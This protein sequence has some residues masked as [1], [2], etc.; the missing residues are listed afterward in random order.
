M[1]GIPFG[2]RS[3]GN[4]YFPPKSVRWEYLRAGNG[5]HTCTWKGEARYYD[6]V[7]NDKV[8]RNAGWSYP[9]PKAAARRIKGHVAFEK[10]VEVQE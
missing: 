9:E 4:V 7:V 1:S 3:D 2:D 6:V 8:A 10:T 5:Q